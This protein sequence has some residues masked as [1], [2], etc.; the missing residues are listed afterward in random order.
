[1]AALKGAADE[2]YICYLQC[3]RSTTN[4]VAPSQRHVPVLRV[5][6]PERPAPMTQVNRTYL[7]DL[8]HAIGELAGRKGF[9]ESRVD[10]DVLGLP[11]GANQVLA[12]RSV[13][14]RLA[15]DAR[16]DHSEECRRNLDKSD[17]T[18]AG[19]RMSASRL[20]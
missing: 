4:D 5:V 19:K 10:E 13:D 9:E 14:G 18:H 6:P 7:D 2:K 16:V 17:A 20:R 11:E 3:F 15:T 12:M 8:G 1:M